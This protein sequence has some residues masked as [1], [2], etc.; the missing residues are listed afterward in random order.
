[1]RKSKIVNII[2]PVCLKKMK[3]KFS[4]PLPFNRPNVPVGDLTKTHSALAQKIL[5]MDR[6]FFKLTFDFGVIKVRHHFNIWFFV[7]ITQLHNLRNLKIAEI[8]CH[9]WFRIF[10]SYYRRCTGLD[11]ARAFA[12]A[13]CPVLYISYNR[14]SF[15]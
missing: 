10:V 1:M 5:L 3:I 7:K 15:S 4:C 2:V 13:S 9:K 6:H 8:S 14:N 12:L 11:S